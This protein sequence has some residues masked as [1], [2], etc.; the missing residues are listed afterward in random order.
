[1]SLIIYILASVVIVIFDIK[2]LFMGFL[3]KSSLGKRLIMY[4]LNAIKENYKILDEDKYVAAVEMRNKVL[5][6]AFSIIAP[7]VVYYYK[8]KYIWFFIGV[9]L[10]ID[11]TFEN[12]S[13]KF[14]ESKNPKNK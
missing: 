12:M 7:M 2:F 3:S 1:M 5:I 8:S 13:K 6:F 11:I 10:A 9:Y 4:K 14:L